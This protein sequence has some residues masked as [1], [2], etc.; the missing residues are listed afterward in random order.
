MISPCLAIPT[1]T[2]IDTPE[3]K[4]RTLFQLQLQQPTPTS[5]FSSA[6]KDHFFPSHTSS[7]SSYVSVSSSFDTVSFVSLDRVLTSSQE[8][9]LEGAAGVKRLEN[10]EDTNTKKTFRDII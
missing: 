3:E 1:G 8:G 7:R 6:S 5:S 2:D 10:K 4:K 9:G